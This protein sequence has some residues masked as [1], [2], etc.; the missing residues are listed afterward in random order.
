MLRDPVDDLLGPA[1]VGV[2][3]VDQDVQGVDSGVELQGNVNCG[4]GRDVQ[5]CF[6]PD[7]ALFRAPGG[8]EAEMM[9][10]DGLID[11]LQDHVIGDPVHGWSVCLANHLSLDSRALWSEEVGR[12]FFSFWWFTLV[13]LLSFAAEGGGL[14]LAVTAPAYD[15]YAGGGVV[16]LGWFGSP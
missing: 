13:N 5:W 10:R 1:A 2:F 14:P 16:Y 15:F 3:T 4:F 6:Q 7:G 8:E 11:G 12:E 9:M